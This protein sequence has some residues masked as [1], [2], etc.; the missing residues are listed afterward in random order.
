MVFMETNYSEIVIQ[1][2]NDHQGEEEKPV[3]AGPPVMKLEFVIYKNDKQWLDDMIE[4]AFLMHFI[5][6]Q[7][8]Q[9]YMGFCLACGASYLKE[10]VEGK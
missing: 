7:A 10:K 8:L 3:P 5:P 2:N 9:E 4:I 6:R 1:P